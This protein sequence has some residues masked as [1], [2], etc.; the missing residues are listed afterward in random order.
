[1]P[2]DHSRD[3]SE[4][5]G[6]IFDS[7]DA[8][9]FLIVVRSSDEDVSQTVCAHK[10]ILSPFQPFN[11]SE[12]SE[13]I[14]ISISRPCLQHFTTFVRYL[15]TR[16]VNTSSSSVQ[17]LH[18]MASRFGAKQLMEDTGRLFVE[19]MPQDPSFQTQLS[20]YDY[21]TEMG[22]LLMQENC[23]RYLAWNYQNLTTSPAWTRLSVQLLQTLL[24]RADLVVPDE[25][26]VLQSVE[27]WI[28]ETGKS[29]SLE[30]QAQLLSHVRFPMISAERLFHLETVSPLYSAHQG[31]Y[32]EKMLKALQFNLLLFNQIQASPAFHKEDPDYQTRIYTA[33]PWSVVIHPSDKVQEQVVFRGNGRVSTLGYYSHTIAASMVTP[34]HNSL[35]FQKDKLRWEASLL[36]RHQDCS[37]AGLSCPSLP[38]ARLKTQSAVSTPQVVFQ[39]R[40]LLMCRGSY[41]CQVQDFKNAVS[42][43]TMDGVYKVAY[44]CPGDQYTFQYVVRPQFPTQNTTTRI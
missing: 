44:P 27:T 18:W 15:Y 4:V 1:H 2:L 12:G 36:R 28:R 42:P 30:T 24:Q 39:N 34:V 25:Y 11:V 20:L 32:K 22:D 35:I 19:V 40:L 26:F 9:D 3:L 14:T 16:K 31:L 5:M 17:C 8:C 21:A 37:H 43:L 13:S 41:V 10:M 38:M 6:R 23:V 29:T 33:K 7:G